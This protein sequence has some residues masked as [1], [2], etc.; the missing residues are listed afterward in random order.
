MA[1]IVRKGDMHTG[2]ASPTPNPFHLG[3]YGGGSANVF[4]NGEPCQRIGDG[5]SCGDA[6]AA[7]SGDVKANGIGVHR[8]GD[9]TTGHGSWVPVSAAT[10]SGNVFANGE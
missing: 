5:I 1:A 6:A 2:H 8:L 9:G 10:A 7:G 4:V 3:E